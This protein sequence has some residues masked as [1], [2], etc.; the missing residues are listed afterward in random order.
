MQS[1]YIVKRPLLTEKATAQAS[2]HNRYLF[3][4]ART[5]RKDDIKRA[6]QDLYG[7]RVVGIAT[8]NQRSRIRRTRFGYVAPR[9]TKTAYVKVHPDDKIELF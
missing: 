9:I 8:R 3:E 1:H 4:V 6:I 2:E 7:V 5:A